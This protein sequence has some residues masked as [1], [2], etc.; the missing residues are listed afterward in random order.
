M[1][2]SNHVRFTVGEYHYEEALIDAG[3]T[4]PMI[5]TVQLGNGRNDGVLRLYSTGDMS[6]YKGYEYSYSGSAWTPEHIFT[7]TAYCSAPTITDLLADGSDTLYLGGWNNLGVLMMK[8]GGGWPAYVVLPGSSDKGSILAMKAA[9]GRNDGV[10]RLY[11]SHMSTSGLVEY[12]WNSG[13]STYEA[14]QLMGTNVGRVG[15][16]QGRNDGVNRIYAVERGGVNVHEFTWN[17]SAF[18]D[19]VI[20]TGSAVSNGSAHVGDGRGDGVQ[21]VYVWAGGLYE[22]TWQG[23]A[24]MAQTMNPDN[25]E[26]YYI[27]TGSIRHDGEPCVYVS[28]KGQGLYEY[29]WSESGT[30]YEVDAISAATGGC[31]IGAGRGDGK[32]RLY[33]ARGTKGHYTEAAVVEIWEEP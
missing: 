5:D 19:S 20:F 23:G 16:G 1:I 27:Y 7:A 33:V 9:N 12:S 21:R 29:V 15:I 2:S 30:T 17:G 25:L 13:S 28:V 32:N 18:E 6:T 11:V 10:T 4:P 22:L 26:R 31:V 8:Y 24:W 3:G 14:L